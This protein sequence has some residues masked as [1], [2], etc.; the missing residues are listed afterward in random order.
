MKRMWK[1]NIYAEQSEAGNFFEKYKI[2]ALKLPQVH[3]NPLQVRGFANLSK[4]FTV[5]LNCN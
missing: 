2:R 5:K 3:F 4:F 1:N